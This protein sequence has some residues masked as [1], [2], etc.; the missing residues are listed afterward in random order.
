MTQQSRATNYS[1]SNNGD[2]GAGSLRQAITDSNSAGGTNLIAW[3]TGSGGTLTLGSNLPG[4]NSNT[5]LDATNA[6]LSAPETITGSYDVPLSGAVTF[7]NGGTYDWTIS[8]VI[9]DGSAAGSLTKTGSGTLVL[10]GANTYSGGTILQG[11]ILN[12][13]SD[14]ALGNASGGLTFEGGT[15][16]MSASTT[17]AR[18]VTIYGTGQFDTN[19]YSLSLTGTISGA[20]QLIKSGAGT[21]SLSGSNSYSGGTLL[22]GGIL[23][24]KS[25]S[26]LGSGAIIFNGGTLQTQTSLSDSHD[27]ILESGGGTFETPGST[28]TFYGLITGSGGLTKVSSGTLILSGANT[29]TGGTTIK[30]GVI[31]VT[32]EGNLGEAHGTLTLDG[33]TLQTA[34]ALTDLRNVTLGASGGTID[35]DGYDSAF[36]GNFTGV[37]GLTKSGLGILTLSGASNNYSGGTTVSVGT[38]QYGVNNA[39]PTSGALAVASDATLDLN[40]YSQTNSLGTV[41]N[42]GLINVGAGQMIMNNGYSGAGT[43]AVKLAQAV[44]NITG[45]NINLNGTTLSVGWA[46]GTLPTIGEVFTPIKDTAGQL[47]G[48]ANIVPPAAFSFSQTDNGNSLILTT[49]FV[50]FANSAAT[51]NQAAVGRAIEPLRYSNN[52]NPIGDVATVLG[53][54]YNLDVPGLQSALDQIGPTSLASIVGLGLAGSDVHN[55]AVGRRISVLADGPGVGNPGYADLDSQW[56]DWGG[57][58]E[59]AIASQSDDSNKT[60]SPFGY[61]ASALDTKG[62]FGGTSG[63]AGFQPGYIFSIGGIDFGADGCINDNLA[64]GVTGAYLR[65]HATVNSTAGGTVDND[66]GRLG[67]YVVGH[68]NDWRASAYVGGAA[69]SYSTNRGIS[70]GDITRS[71]QANPRGKELNMNSNASFDIPTRLLGIFSPFAGLSYDRLNIGAFTEQNADSLDLSVNPETAQSLRSNLGMRFSGKASLGSSAYVMYFSAGWRHEFENQ[72]RAIDAQLASGAGHAFSVMT[73]DLARDGAQFGGGFAVAFSRQTTMNFDYSG[74]AWSP[75]S[76]HTYSIGL[77]M[78]F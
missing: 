9:S 18:N 19:G 2:T 37:G 71:A 26:V 74:S 5:T 76:A 12:V 54:L 67:A 65:D 7:S 36:Y 24:I 48:T 29:Y 21:L 17:S 23:G 49:Q 20:G 78:K 41:I 43:L 66:S 27:I 30:E 22:E 46:A 69:D 55:A 77:H 63:A 59:G 45:Q 25:S 52:N 34:A 35:T 8:S 50:P 70:F 64:V 14:A 28:S 56:S 61:F 42:N 44:T 1:V 15:L 10:T 4:I 62:S 51:P 75:C 60:S 73:G 6:C 68:A 31:S 38:L 33:G 13:N 32:S 39:L 40:G 53:S 72:N 11:G 47:S 3:T 58:G 16:Q 57:S